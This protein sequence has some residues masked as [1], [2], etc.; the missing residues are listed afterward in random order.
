MAVHHYIAFLRG[1]NLGNR[2]LKMDALAALFT[3][4][5]FADVATFIASGNVIFASK[6][7]DSRK[8]EKQIETHL[9]K[10]LGYGVDTFVRTR[11][12]N[13]ALAA[14]RPF[15]KAD[16]ENPANTIFASFTKEPLTAAQARDLLACRTAVDEFCVQG[17]EF[18]WLCRIKSSESKVW[19]TPQMRAVKLPSSSTM[20]NLTTLRKL[21]ARYPDRT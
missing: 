8:L 15:P 1:I 11:A 4:M 9:Q 18:F 17:R 21:A 16:L 20:R 14:F 19:T 7:A 5:K 3:E 10:S 13:A 6:S 12:E 2:R